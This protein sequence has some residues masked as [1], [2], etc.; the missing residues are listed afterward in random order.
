MIETS[1]ETDVQANPEKLQKSFAET[2]ATLISSLIQ[3]EYGEHEEKR[4]SDDKYFCK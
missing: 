1:V 4:S 2:T 3:E